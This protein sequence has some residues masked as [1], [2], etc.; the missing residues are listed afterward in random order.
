M[1]DAI[2]LRGA[3]VTLRLALE[4]LWRQFAFLDIS[5]FMGST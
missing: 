1:D 2:P 4:M 3:A 5:V